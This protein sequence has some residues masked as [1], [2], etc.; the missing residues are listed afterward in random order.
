MKNITSK[1]SIKNIV[2]DKKENI[3]LKNLIDVK[4]ENVLK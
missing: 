1:S 3:L 4:Q 2:F